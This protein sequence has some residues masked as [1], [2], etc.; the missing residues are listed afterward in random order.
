MYR[1]V[2][3]CS[4]STEHIN[5]SI[6]SSYPSIDVDECW[7]RLIVTSDRVIILKVSEIDGDLVRVLVD[8]KTK[9][10]NSTGDEKGGKN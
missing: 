10:Q 3:T 7:H 8:E 1:V 4:F 2:Y 6:R 9:F 5:I